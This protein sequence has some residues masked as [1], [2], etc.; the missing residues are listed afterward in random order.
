MPARE[1]DENI[2][3]TA[4]RTPAADLE[5][6]EEARRLLAAERIDPVIDPV[7]EL[8]PEREAE[9]SREVARQMGLPPEV[10]E[11]PDFRPQP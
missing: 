10:G 6:Q 1:R 5:V 9:V 8:S 4:D 2:D 7:R 3:P 11:D